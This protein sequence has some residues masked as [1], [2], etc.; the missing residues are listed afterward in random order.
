MRSDTSGQTR[1]RTA[2]AAL[3]AFAAVCSSACVA[4]N[5]AA[6]PPDAFVSLVVEPPDATVRFDDRVIGSGAT[7]RGRWV[8]VARGAH[9]LAVNAPG[10]DRHEEDL[11]LAAGRRVVQ[12]HLERTPE[13]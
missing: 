2:I 9:R 8:A 6:P 4:R 12:V 10:F 11:E 7:V 3:V 1:G 13:R 5:P